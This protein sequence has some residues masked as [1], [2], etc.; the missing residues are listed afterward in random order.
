MG[1]TNFYEGSHKPSSNKDKRKGKKGKREN[2][3]EKREI[4]VNYNDMSKTVDVGRFQRYSK[5]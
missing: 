2:N 1:I 3:K 4:L 5:M